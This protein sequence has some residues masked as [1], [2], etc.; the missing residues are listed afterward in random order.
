MVAFACVWN[1]YNMYLYDELTL[2]LP[3]VIFKVYY[4]V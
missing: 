4:S 3:Y 1:H 2:S